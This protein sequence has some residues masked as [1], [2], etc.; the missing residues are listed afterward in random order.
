M[1]IIQG[2]VDMDD[3]KYEMEE[4]ARTGTRIKVIGVGGGGCNAVARMVAEGL[5]GVEFYA[6]NTD[7]QALSACQ[8]PAYSSKRLPNASRSNRS[9]MRMRIQVPIA[10]RTVAHKSWNQWLTASPVEL[11]LHN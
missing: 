6:M 11:R 10:K 2:D 5:D 4:E 3:L 1:G 9:S 8:V 7:V